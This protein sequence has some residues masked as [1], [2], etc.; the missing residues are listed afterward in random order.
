MNM[1]TLQN[2]LKL[3]RSEILNIDDYSADKIYVIGNQYGLCGAI[4]VYKNEGIE[5]ALDEL[6]DADKLKG[7]EIDEIDFDED[8]H[9]RIGN[10]GKPVDL[11]YMWH[12][13]HPV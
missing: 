6:M 12:E 7:L 8:V 10:Y 4:A 9:I 11:T 13:C 5:Y 3:D 1:L 2:G